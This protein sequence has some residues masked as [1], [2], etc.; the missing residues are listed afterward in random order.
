M[1]KSRSYNNYKSSYSLLAGNTANDVHFQAYLLEGLMR[2]NQDR[3]RAAVSIVN[4]AEPPQSYLVLNRHVVNKL[5]EEVFGQ[6]LVPNFKGPNKY[7][8]T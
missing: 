6:P 7:T 3:A 8:G 4:R 5:S 2:W 1:H